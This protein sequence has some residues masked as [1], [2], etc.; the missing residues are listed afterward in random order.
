MQVPNLNI[1]LYQNWKQP[2]IQPGRWPALALMFFVR[3]A[4]WRS[5]KGTWLNGDFQ[6]MGFAKPWKSAISQ[7][8]Q[9]GFEVKKIKKL[10]NWSR[11]RMIANHCS[12][13]SYKAVHCLPMHSRTAHVHANLCGSSLSHY[14][15]KYVSM[16][17]TISPTFQ[18][19]KSSVHL[20]HFSSICASRAKISWWERIHV[21]GFCRVINKI[22]NR[23]DLLKW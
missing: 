13:L 4:G 10:I 5:W 20:S 15:N 9:V 8:V 3:W 6:I 18:T 22:P 19:M 14:K 21:C 12:R 11:L 7:V 17:S 2:E 23:N 1:P 16:V